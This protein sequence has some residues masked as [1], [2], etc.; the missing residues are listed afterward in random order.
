MIVGNILVSNLARGHLVKESL[1][2]VYLC[3][4]H[5][6]ELERFKRALGFGYKVDVLDRTLM[7]GNGPV[8]RVITHRSGNVEPSR[9]FGIDTYL[10]GIV[11]SHSKFML[12]RTRFADTIHKDVITDML[13]GTVG[14]LVFG[15]RLALGK[16]VGIEIAVHQVIG[17]MLY[18]KAVT[19]RYC[20]KITTTQEPVEEKEYK[21]G[22]NTA[23]GKVRLLRKRCLIDEA[24]LII[25]NDDNNLIYWN[26]NK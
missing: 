4:F 1:G 9:K 20:I 16:D 17:D 3:L 13:L 10:I 8:G 26:F 18:D 14:K 25:K 11:K 15:N 21:R 2:T 7:E 19:N 12:D 6:T 22:N 23:I 5:P 24:T